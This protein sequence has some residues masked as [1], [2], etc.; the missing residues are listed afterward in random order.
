[1]VE[2]RRT[3]GREQRAIFSGKLLLSCLI[4]CGACNGAAAAVE[5]AQIRVEG[6]RC[7]LCVTTLERMLGAQP[8]VGGVAVESPSG[9]ITLTAAPGAGLDLPGIRARLAKAGFEPAGDEIVTAVGAVARGENDRLTFRI[10][11][12]KESYDL[13]EGAELRNLLL[14]LPAGKPSRV[15]LRARLHRHPASLPPSLSVLSYEVEAIT[16]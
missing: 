9:R 16:R 13:L 3:S 8:G 5:E 2:C 12:A 7:S 15:K 14:A 11:G 1:M 6:I 10:P 4:L